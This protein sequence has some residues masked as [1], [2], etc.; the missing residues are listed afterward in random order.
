MNNF[1]PSD[2]NKKLNVDLT[3]KGGIYFWRMEKAV[4]VFAW[5]GVK[6]G[7][8]LGEYYILKVKRE[9]Q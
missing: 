7:E 3:K 2:N 1:L 6:A 5:M 9:S 4:F 8:R